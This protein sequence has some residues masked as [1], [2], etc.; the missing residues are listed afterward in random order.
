MT[1]KLSPWACEIKLAHLQCA[2]SINSYILQSLQFVTGV[3]TKT[4]ISVGKKP[5]NS[6]WGHAWQG[7]QWGLHPLSQSN[8]HSHVG[9]EASKAPTLL[10][11]HH[12][13]E[14]LQKTSKFPLRTPA[15]G[16]FSKTELYLELLGHPAS[17]S[18]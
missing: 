4:S 16:V 9:L 1:S 7:Q 18:L 2:V 11:L 13:P 5:E 15:E 6:G 10:R 17:S 14:R 8:H 3:C 12:A